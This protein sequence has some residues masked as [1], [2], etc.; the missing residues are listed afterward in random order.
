MCYIDR[1]TKQREERDG[2]SEQWDKVFARSAAGTEGRGRRQPLINL[3]Q[4]LSSARDLHLVVC[5]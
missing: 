4:Q 5:W 2:K 1:R 3:Y